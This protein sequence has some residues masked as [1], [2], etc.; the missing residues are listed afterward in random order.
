MWEAFFGACGILT[1]GHA[2]YE[3]RLLNYSK[4]IRQIKTGPTKVSLLAM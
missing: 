2:S 4:G 1:D 3:A